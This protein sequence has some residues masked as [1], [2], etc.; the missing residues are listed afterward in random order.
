MAGDESIPAVRITQ[1]QRRQW[2][3]CRRTGELPRPFTPRPERTLTICSRGN[4]S[5]RRECPLP[6]NLNRSFRANPASQFFREERFS[7]LLSACRRG[8]KKWASASFATDSY[9]SSSK[10]VAVTPDYSTSDS[11]FFWRRSPSSFLPSPLFK[12][13]TRRRWRRSN[14]IS[15]SD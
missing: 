2:P 7:V 15:P 13:E 9:T 1:S 12:Y 14:G 3:R 5:S 11:I 6:E 8:A 4:Q 10:T